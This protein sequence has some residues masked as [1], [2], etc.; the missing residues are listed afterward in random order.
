M[1]SGGTRLIDFCT[2]LGPSSKQIASFVFRFPMAGHFSSGRQRVHMSI[3]TG[4][5]RDRKDWEI[6]S[7]VYKAYRRYLDGFNDGK[8]DSINA[9]VQYPLTVISDGQAHDVYTFPINPA[10]LNAKTGWH[11][12]VDA[13]IDVVAVSE[14]KAHVILRNARRLR[15]DGSLIETV[16]G[17]YAFTKTDDGAWRMF[18]ISAITDPE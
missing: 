13:E 15:Q 14:T 10:E 12:T 9:V 4:R 18:A 7:A 5:D 16:S 1:S 3:A 2:Y 11:A 8:M 6:R 17:F